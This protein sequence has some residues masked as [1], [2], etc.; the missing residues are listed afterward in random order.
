MPPRLRLNALR[1][2]QPRTTHYVCNQCRHASL[3]TTPSAPIEQHSLPAAATAVIARHPPTQPP[4]YKPPEFRKSQLHRQYQST[5]RSSPLILLFQHNNLKA[6]EW[7]GIR[8]ELT[9]ALHKVDDDLAKSGAGDA[10]VKVGNGVKLQIVQTGIFA[11]ALKVVEFWD[12]SFAGTT[13][14]QDTTPTPAQALG[15]KHGLSNDA[16]LAAKKHAKTQK[17]GLEPLLSGP[18]ALLTFP[19]VSPQHLKA[20]LSILSPGLDFP[21]PKRRVNPGYHAK[22]VQDGLQKLML[23]GARVD[24]KVFDTQGA[25]WVGSIDGGLGGLRAQL[26]AMLS[27]I[28]AGVTSTLEAAGRSLYFAVEGRRG[29]LEEEEKAA[30]GLKEGEQKE[31]SPSASSN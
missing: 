3:A 30:S 28:G 31:E 5:L 12:P 1:T 2:T 10:G 27:G 29:M 24:G 9:T 18:L 14:A 4:S 19:D 17:H 13:S 15:A 23:L 8:R 20:A 26:V 11:S 22:P 7:S 6:T 16:Y 25:R 21:A